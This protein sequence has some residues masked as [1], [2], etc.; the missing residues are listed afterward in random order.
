M[1]AQL[2]LA[3]GFGA[4]VPFLQGCGN[5]IVGVAVLRVRGSWQGLLTPK[6]SESKEPDQDSTKSLTRLMLEEDGRFSQE[7][8]DLIED[9]H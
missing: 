9:T 1:D 7:E 2:E 8:I 3:K 4:A 5:M 6:S